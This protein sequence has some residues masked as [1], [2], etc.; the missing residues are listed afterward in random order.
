MTT[1][2]NNHFLSVD[3]TATA[4]GWMRPT[5]R[6]CIAGSVLALRCMS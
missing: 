1:I 6:Q 5:A 4:A 2:A 3:A